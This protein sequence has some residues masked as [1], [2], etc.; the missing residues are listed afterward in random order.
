ML[1]NNTTLNNGSLTKSQEF[2]KVTTGNN[3]VIHEGNRPCSIGHE[4]SNYNGGKQRHSSATYK[5][6]NE[7]AYDKMLD[8]N[9]L[10]EDVIYS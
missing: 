2:E 3:T 9:Q 6:P 7:D 1:M 5:R 10:R 8:R 4:N